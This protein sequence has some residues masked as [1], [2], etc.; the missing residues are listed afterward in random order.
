MISCFEIPATRSELYF[1]LSSAISLSN[2]LKSDT[3]KI[4]G[5][6]SIHKD[7]K[8]YYVGQSQN[9]PSRLAD[10]LF[11]KYSTADEFRI[12]FL[13]DG[14][15]DFWM[16]SKTARKVI[17]ENHEIAIMQ[18]LKPIDNIIIDYDR[19]INNELLGYERRYIATRDIIG[20]ISEFNIT[21]TS[22]FEAVLSQLD[23]RLRDMHIDFYK[24]I[25]GEDYEG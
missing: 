23:E 12:Y 17:L 19:E 14:F 24:S 5:L 3:Y 1:H 25:Y 13:G 20:F 7:S 10:H 18:D 15:D 22:N 9:L 21:M 6:Y 8:C 4:A 11:G 16:R 2:P